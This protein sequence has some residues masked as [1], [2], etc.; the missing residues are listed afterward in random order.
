[1]RRGPVTYTRLS[2]IVL[3]E[4]DKAIRFAIDDSE[5]ALDGETFWFPISQMRKIVRG[6]PDSNSLDQIECP[7]WL[8]EAKVNEIAGTGG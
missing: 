3:R 4:T 5:H 6:A 1:M 7:D 2:G 8:I